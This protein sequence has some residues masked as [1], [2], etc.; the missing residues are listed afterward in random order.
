M[1][2]L[3]WT[4]WP[5]RVEVAREIHRSLHNHW[6]SFLN[7]LRCSVQDYPWVMNFERWNHF[8]RDFPG[9]KHE[10]SMASLYKTPTQTMLRSRR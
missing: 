8:R 9:G 4:A 6:A 2:F 7:F 10:K 1:A 5:T 3:R